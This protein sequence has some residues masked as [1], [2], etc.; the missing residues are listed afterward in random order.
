MKRYTTP[1]RAVG[2]LVR[3]VGTPYK[4]VV[5]YSF[6]TYGGIGEFSLGSVSF[7]VNGYGKNRVAHPM[8]PL[9]QSW[10]VNIND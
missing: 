2:E 8:S 9:P 3:I 10:L 6:K 5:P 7:H 1:R 4:I